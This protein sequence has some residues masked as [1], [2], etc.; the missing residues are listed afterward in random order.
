MMNLSEWG[1][2]I[3]PALIIYR[4]AVSMCEDRN[5]GKGSGVHETGWTNECE[6][7]VLRLT[8]K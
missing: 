8:G 5:Y 4:R 7:L 1:T 2:Q 6:G 3:S